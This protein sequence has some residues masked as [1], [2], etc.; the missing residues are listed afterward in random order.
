MW[1]KIVIVVVVI[2]VVVYMGSMIASPKQNDSPV[3]FEATSTPISI[4][5]NVQTTAPSQ[6][7]GKATVV[8]QTNGLA[9]Y[10]ENVKSDGFTMR[11]DNSTDVYTVT[12]SSATVYL[13]D[14]KPA[15]VSDLGAGLA[16][17]VVGKIDTTAHTVMATN[18]IILTVVPKQ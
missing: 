11:R 3:Q 8:S 16:T 14:G 4:K 15:S 5:A 17:I 10:I 1:Q 9:G 13:K 7:G 2:G 6:V 12:T 18:I